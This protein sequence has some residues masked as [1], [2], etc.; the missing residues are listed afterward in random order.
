MMPGGLKLSDV[1]DDRR[2][3]RKNNFDYDTYEKVKH[4]KTGFS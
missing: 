4:V 1:E 2:Q 3:S